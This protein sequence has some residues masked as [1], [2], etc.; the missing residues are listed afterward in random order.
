MI[1]MMNYINTLPQKP[2]NKI[3]G[4]TYIEYIVN[5]QLRLGEYNLVVSSTTT[6]TN[7]KMLQID[8]D[9]VENDVQ[10]I[11]SVNNMINNTNNSGFLRYA[12]NSIETAPTLIQQI[13]YNN[14]ITNKPIIPSSTTQIAEGNNLYYTPYRVGVIAS[15]SNLHTSNY[16]LNSSNDLINYVI[17]K[18]LNVSNYVL[19][20]SNSL[21]NYVISKDINVS[22]YVLTSSNSL[23][24][25][26][27]SKDINVSNY[28]L[29]SSNSLINY[30]ISKDVNVSNYVLTS[31]NSLINYAISK[32]INVSNYVL[33]SSNSLINYVISKDVNVSNYVLT[34]SNSLINYVISK[35]VNVSNY[36]LT[37]S[38]SLINYVISKDVNV[39]NY[40]L[41]TSNVISNR[42]SSLGSSPWTV[43]G[44]VIYYNNG[45]VGIGTTF[46]TVGVRLQV[47]GTIKGWY[48]NGSGENLTTLNANNISSG[49]LTFARGGTGL[50]T[51]AANSLLGSGSSADTLQAI[52]V[53]SGLTLSSGTLT[54]NAVTSS[55]VYNG[56]NG[57]I[58]Y[59]PSIGPLNGTYNVGIGTTNPQYKLDVVGQIMSSS[60]VYCYNTNNSAGQSAIVQSRI[61]GT[62]ADKAIFSFDVSG[63]YGWSIYAAGNDTTNKSLRF[64]NG[65]VGN[66]TDRLTLFQNGNVGIGTT[67]PQYKLDVVGQIMSSSGVYCYNNNNS[68]GQTAVVQSRIGGTSADKAIFSFD[69]AGSYGWSIYSAG[70][71]TTNKSIRFNNG[72]L[73]NGTDILTLFQNGNVGIGLANPSTKL[74]VASGSWSPNLANVR[75]F[76]YNGVSTPYASATMNNICAAFRSDILVYS[77]V[78]TSSDNRIKK[79]IQDI[80]DD[81]ALQKI[82][83]IE[84]KT[85]NYIDE[86]ERGSNLVYGF[87]AQQIR[88]VIPHAVKLTSQVVPNIYKLC[89][90]SSNIIYLDDISKLNINDKIDIMTETKAQT[91][92][93]ITDVGSNYFVI[94]E[95]S[96]DSTK[97]FVYGTEVDDF[98][99]IDKSYI[100]TL[101]VCATQELYRIIERQ[102]K[103]IERLSRICENLSAYVGFTI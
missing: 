77:Q 47:E 50:S 103:E 26:V 58:Y 3:F 16:V 48:F 21:I 5:E 70:N 34:S 69:V 63:S 49:T 44:A 87:I 13:D 90:C 74:D 88:E 2:D 6:N 23:I 92:Y 40:V 55:W 39:S 83:A 72:F 62:S 76:N 45:N 28:V 61:G 67:N 20:S 53:G 43:N 29:T 99:T 12:N 18:D 94:N 42:I 82:L 85:Y 102:G 37:S 98:H 36:V 97:C 79:N 8:N 60:G 93:T 1:D 25:Y 41:D 14:D 38:N 15:A 9:L 75:W 52:T 73:G 30:A 24:N 35:D 56:A 80:N 81:T 17:S 4:K 78:V 10:I 66:G 65:F 31:S 11:N 33:T 68:A 89:D 22:N 84:P 32:D 71:D 19:T 54:A 51:I 46:P 96:L 59:N 57:N 101:N 86:V 7:R 100:Y 95:P 27:I 91:Q 64:N